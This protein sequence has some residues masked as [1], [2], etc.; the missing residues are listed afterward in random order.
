VK[1]INDKKHNEKINERVRKFKGSVNVC[2]ADISDYEK[3]PLSEGL[4]KAFENADWW[5]VLKEKS[6]KFD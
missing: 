5:V 6:R 3:M 4:K 2:T 1:K